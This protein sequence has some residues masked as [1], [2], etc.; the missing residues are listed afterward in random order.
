M[1]ECRDL[2]VAAD[3]NLSGILRV[4]EDLAL[5]YDCVVTTEDVFHERVFGTIDV[6]QLGVA[7]LEILR[8]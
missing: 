3:S 1:Q 8:I 2:I 6:L 5:A 4:D 7:V